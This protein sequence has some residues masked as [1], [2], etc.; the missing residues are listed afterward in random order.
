[1]WRNSVAAI[2][3]LVLAACSSVGVQ[4]KQPVAGASAAVVVGSKGTYIYTFDEE[5]C[6]VG[7]TEINEKEGIRVFPDKEAIFGYEDYP[8]GNRYC[9]WVF[10]FVPERDAKY[11]MSTGLQFDRCHLLVTKT[12]DSASDVPIALN[13]RYLDLP[14]LSTCIRFPSVNKQR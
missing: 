5:G 13:H 7:K 6:Y 9:Q 14:F 11:K 8:M 2:S 4:Y 12:N 10:S 3:V 1:M